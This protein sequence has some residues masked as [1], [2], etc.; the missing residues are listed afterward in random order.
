MYLPRLGGFFF[1]TTAPGFFLSPLLFFFLVAS[2][3]FAALGFW[4]GTVD[5]EEVAGTANARFLWDARLF[6]E[7]RLRDFFFGLGL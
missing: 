4:F 1:V 5:E 6:L 2:C 3:F 7:R